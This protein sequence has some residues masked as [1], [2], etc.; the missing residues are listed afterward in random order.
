MGTMDVLKRQLD[1]EQKG[2]VKEHDKHNQV[3]EDIN[4]KLKE[5]LEASRLRLEDLMETMQESKKCS[6]IWQKRSKKRYWKWKT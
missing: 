4:Q 3:Q 5:D 6:R 2:N 1:N